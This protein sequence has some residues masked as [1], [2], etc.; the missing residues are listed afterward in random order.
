MFPALWFICS[1]MWITG[2]G[3]TLLQRCSRTWH[4]I[5]SVNP[6]MCNMQWELSSCWQSSGNKMQPRPI[7]LPLLPPDALRGLIPVSSPEMDWA[8]VTASWVALACGISPTALGNVLHSLCAICT[9]PKGGFLWLMG[10]VRVI[11][12]QNS[13]SALHLASCFYTG[14][15]IQ[16]RPTEISDT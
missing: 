9:F 15:N 14:A 4:N 5:P 6:E 12:H 3:V 1:T 2:E 13:P 10:E 11:S 7:L 8:K 16:T